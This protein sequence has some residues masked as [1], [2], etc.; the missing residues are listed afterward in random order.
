M[1]SLCTTVSPSTF[2]RDSS[3]ADDLLDT[4]RIKLFPLE[5]TSSVY[6]NDNGC[7]MGPR[8]SQHT[9]EES[10]WTQNGGCWAFWTC[11]D[12]AA[13][14]VNDQFTGPTRAKGSNVIIP[15]KAI[16]CNSGWKGIMCCLFGKGVK[17]CFSSY[18]HESGPRFSI[19]VPHW[20]SLTF[21]VHIPLGS[22]W[23]SAY[24]LSEGNQL[25]KA[26]PTIGTWLKSLQGLT[27]APSLP[28]FTF[29]HAAKAPAWRCQSAGGCCPV[30]MSGL[31]PSA[32]KWRNSPP[33][34]RHFQGQLTLC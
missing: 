1:D 20:V 21:G 27:Y 9:G 22:P 12:I 8:I 32:H 16:S 24:T 26:S 28:L 31:H 13:A 23:D 25:M 11:F 14:L 34:F 6:G 10:G 2:A 3:S 29:N 17:F 4:A 19:T 18:W 15:L 30:H 33:I 7:K 5:A